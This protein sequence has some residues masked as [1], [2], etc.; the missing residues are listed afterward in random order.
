MKKYI[1]LVILALLQFSCIKNTGP[2]ENIETVIEDI[3]G[4][5]APDGRVATFDVE[6]IAARGKIILRGET[7]FPEAKE[8]LFQELKKFDDQEFVDSIVILPEKELGEIT[9]GIVNL[10]VGNMRSDPRHSAEMATQTLLGSPM[11]IYKQKGYWFRVQSPDKYL[12]WM[13]DEALYQTDKAGYDAWIAAPK[14]IVTSVYTF[15][16]E[17]PNDNSQTVSDIVAGNILKYIGK[18]GSWFKVEYPDGRT[19]F[20]SEKDADLFDKWLDSRELTA[21]NLITTAKKLMGVPY[22]WG[23]TSPKTFDCSGFTK[24]V[25]F[26]NGVI[27][28]RD[29]SQ[30][31]HTGI[32]VDT[33][34]GFDNLQPGDLLFFGRKASE[35]SKERIT[36]VALYMGDSEFIHASGM[37]KINSLDKSRDNFS[38][39][40]FNTFVKAKRFVTSVGENGVLPISDS[41]L[42]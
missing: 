17:A 1:V 11:R 21:E 40:R 16:Y 3:K 37:V 27:L 8:K 18:Q 14:V 34:N 15:S 38:Q 10:S 41:P 5:F 31:V 36:H 24:T 25:F 29:A 6:H 4:E 30:Q 13:G 22:M 26:L 7:M 2:M 20:I 23:G 19:A 33:K 28:P 35:D 42:Y 32:L 12:G 9:Y 39:Y